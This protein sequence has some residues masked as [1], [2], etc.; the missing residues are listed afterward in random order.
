M[1]VS[2]FD[3]V[4]KNYQHFNKCQI[5]ETIQQ[6]SITVSSEENINDGL[7]MLLMMTELSW[8]CKWKSIGESKAVEVDLTC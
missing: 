3:I 4:K 2:I 6:S 7:I 8:K 5:S 1:I